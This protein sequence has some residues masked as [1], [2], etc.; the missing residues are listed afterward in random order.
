MF[1]C[2]RLCRY[3]ANSFS[4]SLALVQTLLLHRCIFSFAVDVQCRLTFT[5]THEI[6]ETKL[7]LKRLSTALKKIFCCQ[8]RKNVLQ[9]NVKRLQNKGSFSISEL[10]LWG[11]EHN[12]MFYRSP[13]TRNT[14][15]ASLHLRLCLFLFEFFL[16]F[17][18]LQHFAYEI[19]C[20]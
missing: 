4:L 2:T 9:R 16:F 11:S 13:H 12:E 14:T 15:S 1:S 6:S 8:K 19:L 20:I 5:R 17:F 7:S 10:R 18:P 3:T